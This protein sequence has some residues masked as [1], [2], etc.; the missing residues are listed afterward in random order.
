MDL[1][2]E[3][4]SKH[5]PL[6]ERYVKFRLPEVADKED[7]IQEIYFSAFKNFGQLKNI[8][9][10][11][12]WIIGIAINK[13]NDWYKVNAKKSEIPID[14]VEESKLIYGRYGLTESDEVKETLDLMKDKYRQMLDLYFIKEMQQKDI[15]EYLSIPLGTVKSRI[16]KAKQEFKKIYPYHPDSKKGEIN[17]KI[18]PEILPEYKIEYS[19]KKPFDVKWEEL[20]GWFLVPKLGEKITWGMYDI[21]SRKCNH[22]FDMKVTGKAMVHGIEGVELTAREA[23]YSEKK[24]AI[25]RTFVAQLTDTHCRYLATVR[26]D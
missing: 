25:Y 21:P 2:E 14:S 13:C 12:A 15:S 18:I 19:D 23:N 1:F 4:L 22:I 9:S 6:V 16:Y 7:V 20:M 5:S 3:L 10:F 17:M 26:N 8:N 24:E 11:K